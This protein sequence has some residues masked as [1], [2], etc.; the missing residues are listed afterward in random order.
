LSGA[1]S[2][3]Y[4]DSGAMIVFDPV[5]WQAR[6]RG[7]DGLLRPAGQTFPTKTLAERWLTTTEAEIVNSDWIDP[8]DGNTAFRDYA[9]AWLK[10]RPGLRPATIR[11]CR[12]VLSCHVLPTF[13]SKSLSDIRERHVRHWYKIML[14][15]GV[16]APTAAKAYVLL[17]AIIATAVDDGVLRRNPCRVKGAGSQ[18]SPERPV[19]TIRQIY[20]LADAVGPRYRALVLLAAFCS[21]RWGELAALRGTDVD[22]GARTVRVERSLQQV[23][24]GGLSFG[25][26]KSAAGR[27]TVI[28]PDLILADLASHLDSHGGTGSSDLVFTSPAGETLH[29]GNFRKRVW[30]PALETVGL[31]N[32]HVHD[33]RHA[34]NVL[35][36]DVGANLRELME[37]MGHITTRAALIYLH[38]GDDRQ[39]ALAAGV[40]DQ[41]RAALQSEGKTRP[42]GSGTDLAR[43][44]G[45]RRPGTRST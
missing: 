23:A 18:Q 27:R 17:K 13:G 4:Q 41:V 3:A 37:R 15:G 2:S 6:Y 38:G 20:E 28:I 34:G 12:S 25:P 31:T 8:Q 35:V 10:E 5:T 45:A 24:G 19:V 26:P 44:A 42:L 22:L 29:H 16:G 7:P 36:A 33:L 14:D 40:S 43:A 21:L 39:R 11:S 9:A 32:V 30:L 1:R